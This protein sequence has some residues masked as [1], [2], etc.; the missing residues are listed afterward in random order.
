MSYIS[1]SL[2]RADTRTNEEK[3]SSYYLKTLRRFLHGISAASCAIAT[4]PVQ[5]PLSVLTLPHAPMNARQLSQRHGTGGS[6]KAYA[7]DRLGARS[8]SMIRRI[9]LSHAGR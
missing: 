7:F 6:F 1:S 3:P 2:D 4:P 8:S 9:S 5:I